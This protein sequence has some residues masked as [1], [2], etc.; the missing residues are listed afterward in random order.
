[1]GGDDFYI[2]LLFYNINLRCYVVIELKTGEFK[3]EYAGQLNF[4]LSAV[5][6]ILKKPEDNPT[7]GLLLCKNKNDLVAEYSL[8]DMNKP[9][10]ISEYKVTGILPDDLATQL[11]SIEDI[12][13][14][15]NKK[16]GENYMANVWLLTEEQKNIDMYLQAAVNLYGHIT[17][18]QFLLI[19]NKYNKNVMPKLLKDKLMK[20]SNKLNRQAKN[21]YI[22]D[23]AI[24]NTTVDDEI[25][26]KII[27]YQADK[28]YYV[29]EKEEFLKWV[30]DKY[31]PITPQANS[32]CNFLMT[33]YKISPETVQAVIPKVFHSI[34]IDEKTQAQIDIFEE[35]DLSDYF[36]DIDDVSEFYDY[37]VEFKNNSRHWTN[38]GFT[39]IEMHKFYEG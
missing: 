3:P 14:R 23:N 36:E 37:F 31:C 10:G 6:G 26:H 38:C 8:K 1:M 30:N 39:P 5:D 9:I 17:P 34:L 13:K 25:M 22:Y 12:E 4:Y 2:D 21:Y 11:P 33:K 18:K 20:Y 24:I 16:N 19:Y 27:Y 32:L 29:P 15:I 7:I 35:Y 28:K